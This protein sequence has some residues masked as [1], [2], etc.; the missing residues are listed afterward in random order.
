MKRVLIRSC[1]YVT[2]EVSVFVKFRPCMIST[3]AVLPESEINRVVEH[4]SE[5]QYLTLGA[6]FGSWDI[7]VRIFYPVMNG[8]TPVFII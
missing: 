3:L 2:P 6:Q 7:A 8:L 4:L 5:V 1:R